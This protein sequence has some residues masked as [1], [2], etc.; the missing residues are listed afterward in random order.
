MPRRRIT[1]KKHVVYDPVYNSSIIAKLINGIMQD[2]KKALAEKIVYEAMDT[3]KDKLKEDPL[4]VVLKA[5]ENVRPHVETRSRR[6]GGATYQ[7]PMEVRKERSYSLGIRWM[8]QNARERDGKSFK[9]K[10]MGEIIDAYN[11]KGGAM[12]KRET[13]QKMA[14]SN[15]AFAHYRW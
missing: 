8:I 2:G 6:V 10:L 9:E 14:E 5:I 11:K 1:K 13:V 4:K 3:V 15:R 12:K 7:V